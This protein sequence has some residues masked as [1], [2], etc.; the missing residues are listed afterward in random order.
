MKNY[1]T[2]DWLLSIK[3][4]LQSLLCREMKLTVMRDVFFT[5]SLSNAFTAYELCFMMHHAFIICDFYFFYF[6]SITIRVSCIQAS[7]G[8]IER[9][10]GLPSFK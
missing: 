9:C 8:H 6:L 4:F 5:T 3:V 10:L 7:T 1:L 2:L